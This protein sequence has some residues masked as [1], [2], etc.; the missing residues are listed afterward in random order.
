MKYG[1]LSSPDGRID[2]AWTDVSGQLTLEWVERGGPETRVPTREG[3]GT[4]LLRSGARQ[5]QGTVDCHFERTGL[6]CKLSLLL[7]KDRE[8]E[9][10]DFAPRSRSETPLASAS[11]NFSSPPHVQSQDGNPLG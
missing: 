2:I 1:A 10:V 7:S 5:F 11:A 8:R 4:K 9:T 3:F 6:R